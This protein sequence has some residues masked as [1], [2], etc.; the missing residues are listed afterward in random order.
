MRGFSAKMRSKS[1][2]P[3]SI[4][5]RLLGV[6]APE[7]PLAGDILDR[8]SA[9]LGLPELRAGQVGAIEA[10][11]NERRPLKI[12]ITKI[13]ARQISYDKIG[14]AEVRAAE[15]RADEDCAAEVRED[16]VRV[17]EVREDEV[18]AAEVRRD[19][20]ILFPPLIPDLLPLFEQ[21]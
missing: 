9:A 3:Y 15:V 5:G 11:I 4:L 19:I 7:R 21:G 16:E 14:A 8:P 1:P 12:S 17:T 10:T 13:G 6:P 2:S 18:R 20:R